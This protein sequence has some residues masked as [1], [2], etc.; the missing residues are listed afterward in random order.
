MSK[1]RSSSFTWR[2]VLF[3]RELL[4]KGVR[5]GVGEGSCIKILT[6]NWIPGF[7]PERL[8]PLLPLPSEV[9]VAFLMDDVSKTW[10]VDRVNA[11]FEE[12]V[13][14]A[15]FQVPISRHGGEDFASW[16]HD[17]LGQYT[18]RSAYNLA[19]SSSFLAAHSSNGRG[20]P[21]VLDETVKKWKALW[22]I[23]A[24]GKMKINLWRAAHDCLPTG[25]QLR[26]R[27]IPAM[28]GCIFCNRDDPIEHVLLFCPFASAVWD[29]VRKSFNLQLGRAALSNMKQWIFDF[30]SR[31]SELQNKVM[32][33]TIWHIWQ[34]RNEAKNNNSP[35]NPRR[36]AQSVVAYVNMLT[37]FCFNLCPAPRCESP[38]SAARWVPPPAGTFL[39]NTDAAIF[40]STCPLHCLG[41]WYPTGNPGF[42]LLFYHQ[43][44][45]SLGKGS[46]FG[47]L[48]CL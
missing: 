30:I 5:W 39:I 34:A 14:S 4:K 37:Q 23:K 19:T 11:F 15:I 40:K 35:V 17:K 8:K 31:G 41:R 12:E 10:D 42:R 9:T 28:E 7:P 44:N 38:S 32:V 27:H 2:S 13:A 25:F 24:P 3:G 22:K 29:E 36:V 1:P 21:S 46:F 33:V 45:T 43:K 48:C 6:D 47:W 16:P 18:V 20:L 26:R